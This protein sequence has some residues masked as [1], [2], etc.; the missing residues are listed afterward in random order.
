MSAAASDETSNQNQTS[1]GRLKLL[2]TAKPEILF[3]LPQNQTLRDRR[4]PAMTTK[5]TKNTPSQ[6][7]Q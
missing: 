2:M 4:K 5:L 1:R 3:R 7:P 6:L